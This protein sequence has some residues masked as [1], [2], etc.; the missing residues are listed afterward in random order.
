LKKKNELYVIPLSMAKLH[1]KNEIQQKCSKHWNLRNI[2]L[3]SY[4]ERTSQINIKELNPQTISIPI[5][6]F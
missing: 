5:P 4:M 3:K 2:E 1:T 6:T